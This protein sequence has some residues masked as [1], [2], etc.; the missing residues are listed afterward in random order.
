MVSYAAPKK[1]SRLSE[2]FLLS[3][4]CRATRAYELVEAGREKR[5]NLLTIA[6]ILSEVNAN[7]YRSA[8]P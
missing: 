8:Y 6:L 1:K 2:A 7:P 4:R 3:V 5:G